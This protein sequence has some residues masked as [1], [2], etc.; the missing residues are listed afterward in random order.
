MNANN[1]LKIFLNLALDHKETA[2]FVENCAKLD[3]IVI[4]TAEWK[5]I[6]KELGNTNTDE[7]IVASVLLAQIRTDPS[8]VT[9]INVP[10]SH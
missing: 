6:I 9:V 1:M 3:T 2:R 7:E 5:K 8:S 10:T 4:V